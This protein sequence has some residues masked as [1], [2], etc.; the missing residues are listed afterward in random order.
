MLALDLTSLPA[1]L[2]V[3]LYASRALPPEA[4]ARVAKPQA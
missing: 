2:A 1:P 4:I 3:Y